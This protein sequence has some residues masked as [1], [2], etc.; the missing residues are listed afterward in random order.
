MTQSPNKDLNTEA[1]RQYKP[2][3]SGQSTHADVSPGTSA[4]NVATSAV[5]AALALIFSYIEVLIPFQP[6]LPGVKLGLANLVVIVCLY[7]MNAK[8]ALTINI[9]RVI[10]AGLLFTGLW[11]LVYSLAGAEKNKPLFR[12]RREHGRRRSPQSRAAPDRGFC[13]FNG[14]PSVLFSDSHCLRHGRRSDH[15]HRGLYPDPPDSRFG[16]AGKSVQ[17]VTRA[18]LTAALRHRAH[19]MPSSIAAVTPDTATPRRP[20][21]HF[22]FRKTTLS[23]P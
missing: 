1:S 12:D 17:E 22:V 15:R 5:L 23:F 8:Y 21:L 6:G 16:S 19:P 9:I 11:G 18:A 7:R 4:R 10:V 3:A 14:K 20:L 13:G 2:S